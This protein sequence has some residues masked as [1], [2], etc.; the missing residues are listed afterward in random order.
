MKE[1]VFVI[2]VNRYGRKVTDS[3]VQLWQKAGGPA[4]ET[5]G[6]VSMSLISGLNREVNIHITGVRS[7]QFPQDKLSVA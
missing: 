7:I 5:K 6:V 4:V 3:S 2:N 1:E